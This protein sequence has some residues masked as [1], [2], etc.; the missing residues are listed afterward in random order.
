MAKK[1][2]INIERVRYGENA[3]FWSM[4]EPFTQT[5]IDRFE[6]MLDVTYDRFITLVSEGRNMSYD[7]AE[8]NAK[9]RVWTGA[10]ALERNLVDGLGGLGITLDVLAKDLGLKDQSDV[11]IVMFPKP[12]TRYQE[13]ME[14]IEKQAV[15]MGVMAKLTPMFERLNVYLDLPEAGATVHSGLRGV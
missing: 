6:A 8:Y 12:K 3:G 15:F 13:I 2:N 1:L 10:Q 11:T 4:T 7:A 5:Q 14:L 9:G